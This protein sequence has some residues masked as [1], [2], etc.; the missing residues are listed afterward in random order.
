[1]KFSPFLH[2]ARITLRRNI[3]HFGVYCAAVYTNLA[4]IL[5]DHKQA[6]AVI[7]HIAFFIAI[8]IT[9]FHNGSVGNA[10]KHHLIP[11]AMIVAGNNPAGAALF[12]HGAQK[13]IIFTMNGIRTV[14]DSNQFTN[15]ERIGIRFIFAV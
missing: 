14:Y 13:Q 2:R 7:S 6:A 9:R 1:M 12:Q 5:R 8:D 11:I 3:L 10:V 15:M 4:V